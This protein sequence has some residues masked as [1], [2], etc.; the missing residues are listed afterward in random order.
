[1][2]PLTAIPEQVAQLFRKPAVLPPSILPGEWTADRR[3][4]RTTFE[5]VNNAGTTPQRVL[6]VRRRLAPDL[7][8]RVVEPS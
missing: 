8:L 2:S 7:R 5:E 4:R 1:M 3:Q 6:F